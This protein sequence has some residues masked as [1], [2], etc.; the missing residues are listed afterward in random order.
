MALI[1]TATELDVPA[2]TGIYGHYVRHSAATFEIEPPD[3]TEM[4]RHRAEVI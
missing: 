1:K 3:C 4:R 2:I